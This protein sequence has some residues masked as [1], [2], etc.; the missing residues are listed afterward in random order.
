[1]R[2]DDQILWR[3]YGY[4]TP[5]GGKDVQKW[6]NSLDEI[7][8]DEAKDVLGYL[9]SQPR[10]LWNKPEFDSFDADISEIRFKVGA[11][12]RIYRIYGAFWPEG[13]RFSYTFL[14]GKNKKV[15]NDRRGKQEAVARLKRLRRFE[16][17]IH[18]FEFEKQFDRT[19]SARAGGPSTV[20]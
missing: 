19:P 9:Q 11:F 2:Q 5:T 3:F 13:Q 14:I 17:T 15:N 6:F 12:R 20:C 7:E 18:E 10:H 1:M 16:A 4:S 8:K